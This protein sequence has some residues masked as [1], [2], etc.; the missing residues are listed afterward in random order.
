MSS[1]IVVCTSLGLG[2]ILDEP[3]Q[4]KADEVRFFNRGSDGICAR[5]FLVA[6]VGGTI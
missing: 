3:P 2:Y 5:R 6:N 1:K 4:V